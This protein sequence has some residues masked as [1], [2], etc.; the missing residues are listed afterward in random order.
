M[1]LTKAWVVTTPL[2]RFSQGHRYGQMPLQGE[3]AL[4][5]DLG[6]PNVGGRP[7]YAAT[8]KPGSWTRSASKHNHVNAQDLTNL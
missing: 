3:E 4:Q 8:G 5:L 6:G 1:N 2:L 7:K